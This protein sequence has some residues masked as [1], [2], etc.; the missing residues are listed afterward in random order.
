MPGNWATATRRWTRF[1]ER[2]FFSTL[3]NV[4]FD[5]EEFLNPGSESGD[6]YQDHEAAQAGAHREVRRAH[7]HQGEDGNGKRVRH[8]HYHRPDMNALDKLLQ[9]VEGTGCIRLH[10]LRDAPRPRLSGLEKVQEPGRQSGQ[11]LV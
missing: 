6:E 9:Q 2:G 4:N 10:P 5:P 8:R 11:S 3:T 1:I 7:A